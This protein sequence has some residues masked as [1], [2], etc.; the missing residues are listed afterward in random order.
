MSTPPTRMK[1]LIKADLRVAARDAEQLLLTLGI[2]VVLLVFFGTI[3]VF[4][5]QRQDFVDFLTPGIIALALISSAFVRQAISLGFDVSFGAIRR[6]GVTPLRVGEFLSAKL[7]T[8]VVLFGVQLMVLGVVAILLGWR[9]TVSP[10]VV[11][12]IVLG[13]IAFVGLAFVLTG[14]VNG[15]TALAAAN[16]LYIVMLLLSGLV[17]ELDRLPDFLVAVVKLLPSTALAQLLRATLSGESGAGW[18]WISLVCWAVGTPLVG[19]KLFRWG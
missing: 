19:A 2:P 7:M 11:P 14:V 9:P 15:L 10:L 4:E 16:A 18:A 3:D 6:F 13:L 1:A 17:F 5:S 12:V 8:T